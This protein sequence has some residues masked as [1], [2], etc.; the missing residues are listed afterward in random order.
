MLFFGIGIGIDIE[1]EKLEIKNSVGLGHNQNSTF[2]G[3]ICLRL[4]YRDVICHLMTYN[5]IKSHS[6]TK[7][8][9]YIYCR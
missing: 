9:P 4:I 3:K 8:F 7:R 1:E 6:N 5:M 2:N